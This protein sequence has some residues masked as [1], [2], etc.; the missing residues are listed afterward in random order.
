M[1]DAMIAATL[2]FPVGAS[3]QAALP[4]LDCSPAMTSLLLWFS[5]ISFLV[6]GSACFV[7]DYMRGEFARYG[8]ARQRHLVGL[9]QIMGACGLLAGIRL[10]GIGQ[11]AAAGLALLMLL[12]VGVRIKIKDSFLQTLPAMSY[13]ALNIYLCLAAFQGS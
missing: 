13:L 10:P 11:L 6:F 8:L 1:T 5:S 12:G 4:L 9:L 2:M 3:C 7:T